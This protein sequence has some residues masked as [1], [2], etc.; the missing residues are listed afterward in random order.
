MRRIGVMMVVLAAGIAGATDLGLRQEHR[1]CPFPERAFFHCGKGGCILDV[2]K[3][4]FNAKGDGKTDDTEAM[5]RA[6]RYVRDHLDVYRR[7]EEVHCTQ[8]RRKNWALYLPDGTYR[9]SGSVCQGWPALGMTQRRGWTN[10]DYFDVASPEAEK[11]LHARR[12]NALYAEPAWQIRVYGQSREGTVIRLDDGAAGFGDAA[13]PKPLM[14]FR[15]LEVGS[16]INL[17]NHLENLTLDTGR[18]N[19]GA[20]GLDWACSNFGAVR[21]VRILS[22]DGRGRTAI[23]AVTRN[24][25]SE[26]HGLVLDGFATGLR[27]KAGAESVITLSDSSVRGADVAFDVGGAWGTSALVLARVATGTSKRVR[28]SGDDAL[29]CEEPDEAADFPPTEASGREDGACVEDFGAV[30]DGLT[31]DTEAVRRA[32]ASGRESV[33]FTRPIYRLDGVIDVPP[34]VRCVDGLH[35]HL[36]CTVA[37]PEAMFRVRDGRDDLV[38]KRFYCIGGTM[39]DHLA[40][41]RLVVEDVYCEFP[42]VQELYRRAPCNSIPANAPPSNGIWRVY[43]NAGPSVRKQLFARNVIGLISDEPLVNVK[44]EGRLLD[45]EHLPDACWTF[46]DCGVRI[47]GAK[48]E[49]APSVLDAVGS[50]VTLHGMGFLQWDRKWADVPAVRLKDSTSDLRMGLLHRACFKTLVVDVTGSATNVLRSADIAIPPSGVMHV[51]YRGRG[52]TNG[53]EGARRVTAPVHEIETCGSDA[54]LGLRP[55]GR[56]IKT[57]SLL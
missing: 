42:H 23:A 45:T 38:V 48:G 31:D 29:V 35:A 33:F 19:P 40:P 46:R 49:N 37:H 55:P 17:G 12:D 21:N 10:C 16:N 36:V 53:P 41:R 7:G 57:P 18:G 6:M 30:G 43:R 3:P 51:D 9:V 32:M 4:P 44:L 25:C 5:C 27:F 34:S 22:R 56:A 1:H 52:G 26:M 11:A 28:I 47:L 50:Q 8:T 39:V 2:T 13:H 20:V 15:M 14:A 54:K 24:A